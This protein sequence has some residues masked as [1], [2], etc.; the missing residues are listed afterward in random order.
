ML[1][2]MTAVPERPWA[3]LPS[4]LADELEPVLPALAEEIIGALRRQIP[5]Y[6]QPLEGSFGRG[7]RRGVENALADF[8]GLVRDAS[9]RPAIGRSTYRELGA[10]E[11]RQ[12]RSIDALQAAYR[13][14]ARIAWRRVGDAATRAGATPEVLSTLAESIFAYIDE[15]AAES[16]AGYAEEQSRAAGER[17]ARRAELARLLIG[18]EASD[19]ALAQAAQRAEWPVPRA[20]AV[21]AADGE[22]SA[23]RA[24]AALG[25]DVLRTGDDLLVVPDPEGPGAGAALRRALAGGGVGLGPPAAPSHAPTSARLAREALALAP[26]GASAVAAER[27]ADITLA[28][29]GEALDV[30]AARRLAGL[31]GLSGAKR[32]RLE[33]TLLS[34][35]RHRGS[36]P[37]VAAELHVH[38]QTVRYRLATLR[39]ALGAG[40]LED[41]EARFELELVLRHRA[42]ARAREDD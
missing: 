6:D 18:G 32:E 41:P 4:P 36:A 28:R 24:A 8:L 37:R 12:G 23:R 20:V 14:G 27:L 13:L 1:V 34:W 40:T 10:G 33:A 7:V 19:A 5:E 26:P 25:P 9:A 31:G 21:L 2:T 35:L 3:T 11:W 16:V 42:Q 15:L 39:E 29:S 22:E 38:P 17:V 30:L